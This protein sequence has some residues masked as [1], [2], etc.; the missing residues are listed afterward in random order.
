[1]KVWAHRN[2]WAPAGTSCQDRINQSR[3]S[4]SLLYEQP[5]T[6]KRA[7]VVT[8]SQFIDF[9]TTG[10]DYYSKIESYMRM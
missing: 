1:M 10:Y 9:M 7:M 4:G 2:A 3:I 6:Q 5:S 8:I